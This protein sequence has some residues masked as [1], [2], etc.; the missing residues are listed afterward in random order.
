LIG[1]VPELN[2]IDDCRS[3]RPQ[4]HDQPNAAIADRHNNGPV[5]EMPSI[6]DFSGILIGFIYVSLEEFL[7]IFKKKL[8]NITT[9][10]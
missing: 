1:S 6:N 7:S 10:P 5:S 9:R 4:S 2:S 3:L 8:A